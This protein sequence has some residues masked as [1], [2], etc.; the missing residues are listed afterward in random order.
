MDLGNVVI[1][2]RFSWFFIIYFSCELINSQWSVF[3]LF[4]VRNTL[5]V[6]EGHNFQ[7]LQNKGD[8]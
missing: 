2:H 6:C 5:F 3:C 7:P 4:M 8:D 1:F